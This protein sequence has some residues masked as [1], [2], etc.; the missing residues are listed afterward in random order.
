LG[1]T[2]K[3]QES[4]FDPL[5]SWHDCSGNKNLFFLGWRSLFLDKRPF[6]G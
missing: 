3:C 6:N 2:A 5:A 4:R 1:I